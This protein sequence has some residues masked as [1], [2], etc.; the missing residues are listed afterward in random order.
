MDSHGLVL[1][2]FYK[3]GAEKGSPQTGKHSRKARIY[4]SK[5]YIIKNEHC[6][7]VSGERITFELLWNLLASSL[8]KS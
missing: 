8:P 3:T 4:T 7:C 1:P 2:S 5:H 6:K